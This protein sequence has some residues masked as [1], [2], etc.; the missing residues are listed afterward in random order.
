MRDHRK[1]QIFELADQLVVDVY[2][3][4]RGFPS[5]ERYGLVTQMRRCAVSVAA[6]IVEGC[7][8][9]TEIEF[10][11]FLDISFGSLREFG[12][13]IDLSDRPGFLAAD[14]RCVLVESQ[15]RAS[16]AMASIISK[17]EKFRATA[18]AP[19]V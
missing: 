2:K 19:A 15:R 8:R 3:H 1:L 5:E 16:G 7:G 10:D 14:S 9:R 13:S 6:N 17:R 4:T 11:R 12:Y 18:T